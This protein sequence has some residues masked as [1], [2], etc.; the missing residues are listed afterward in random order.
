MKK[1]F[2]AE[3]IRST[4]QNKRG[5]AALAL[6]STVSLGLTSCGTG[7]AYGT[8]KK[9][10]LG[11]DQ[12]TALT[13]DPAGANTAMQKGIAELISDIDKSGAKDD[14]GKGYQ[15]S[16]IPSD[17]VGAASGTLTPYANSR[18]VLR[19]SP[20]MDYGSE[21]CTDDSRST[22]LTPTYLSVVGSLASAGI[23]I[24]VTNFAAE[25]TP[26]E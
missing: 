11:W 17:L 24:N 14:G 18:Y 13:S 3:T 4:I 25:S 6:V 12:L 2:S 23:N 21:I 22:Y 9:C 10:Q 20:L 16:S 8:V 19:H 15:I 7:E 1:G 26:A 5:L